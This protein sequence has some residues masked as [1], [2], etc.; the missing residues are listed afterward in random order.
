M[1][2]SIP[3]LS[4][5]SMSTSDV[6]RAAQSAMNLATSGRDVAICFVS[7]WSGA[8]AR[9]AAPNSVSGRVVK[10]SIGSVA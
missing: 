5:F 8:S 3:T 4:A 7:G 9:K 1:P 6:P 10:T 2:R